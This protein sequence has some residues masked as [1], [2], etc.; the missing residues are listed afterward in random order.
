DVTH[1]FALFKF[2]H[3]GIQLVVLVVA[4]AEIAAQ[5]SAEVR[6]LARAGEH[7]HAIAGGKHHAFVNARLLDQ[8]AHHVRQTF[9]GNSQPLA[10]LQRRCVVVHADEV[11]IHGP[12]NLC[13]W[14]K[15]LAAQAT[16]ATANAKVAI[17]AARRP[18]QP[19]LQRV[20][21]STVYTT[22]IKIERRTLGSAKYFEPKRASARIEPAIN[23]KVM[24]GNPQIRHL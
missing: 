17:Y 4:Q 14:L 23:P 5:K 18:R 12:I 22:H 21:N 24:K 3:V 6:A 11:E 15:L 8:G 16:T 1:S 9:F 2:V 7:F 13:V 19:A 10:Q 20:Y